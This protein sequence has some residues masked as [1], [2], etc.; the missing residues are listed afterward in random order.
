MF[1]WLGNLWWRWQNHR[2][3]KTVSLAVCDQYAQLSDEGWDPAACHAYLRQVT[4][5]DPQ[6]IFQN[7]HLVGSD[8]YVD[9]LM[10]DRESAAV[11]LDLIVNQH[12]QA[13]IDQGNFL[14]LTGDRYRLA[15]ALAPS[16]RFFTYF[17]ELVVEAYPTAMSLKIDP[18]GRK[19]HLFRC[20]LDRMAINFIR[21]Y[22]HD[23][24]PTSLSDYDRLLHYC[25]DHQ[26]E[27]D[28]QTGANYHNRYHQAFAYP[29]N[30]KLQLMK[31]SARSQYNDARMI[32]FIVNIASGSF[33]SEWNVYQK[34]ADG[35][36]DAAPDHYSKAELYQVSNTESF[37]YGV[38]YGVYHVPARY[39]GTHRRL[40]INQPQ[41][42][43]IRHEAKKYWIYPHDYDHHGDFTELV[44]D[45]GDA[46]VQAWRAVPVEQ[47]ASV[48]QQF[49]LYL[50]TF[51]RANHGIKN[52][53]DN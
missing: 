22:Q 26:L 23:Q 34:G 20:Y 11:K 39:R 47:R 4:T 12:L 43:D 52:F 25:H 45:G 44:K 28:Y 7:V 46:D 53:L 8:Q 16:S 3:L 29:Q 32:E 17:R 50:Q 33:V 27:L 42:S 2:L 40:D 1:H 51:H 38:P 18:L 15:H 9:M 48:Y 31:D 37:N 10:A 21:E 5:N 24:L 30:M 6:Q 19:L 13:T 35:A 41:D 36:V 14:Q 49:L